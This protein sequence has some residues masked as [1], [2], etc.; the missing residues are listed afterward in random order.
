MLIK[1][2]VSLEGNDYGGL[3]QQQKNWLGQVGP[4]GATLVSS[5]EVACYLAL[6]HD[7]VVKLYFHAKLLDI[8]LEPVKVCTGREIN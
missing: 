3:D 6:S 5:W 7:Y 2:S 1:G 4:A 8:Q